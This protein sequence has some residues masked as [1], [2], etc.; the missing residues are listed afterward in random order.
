MMNAKKPR[1]DIFIKRH[2]PFESWDGI[3]AIAHESH[4]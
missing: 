4:P 3:I 2:H 1:N